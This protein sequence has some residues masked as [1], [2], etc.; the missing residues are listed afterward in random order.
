MKDF[1]II[2]IDKDEYL[3]TYKETTNRYELRMW[4]N[5]PMIR[6]SNIGFDSRAD[7]DMTWEQAL[8]ISRT[9]IENY[10]KFKKK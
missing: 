1:E 10:E 9:I 3:R 4:K 2:S 6:L 5:S 8:K 7:F